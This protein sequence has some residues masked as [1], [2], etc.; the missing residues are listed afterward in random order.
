MS[1]PMASQNQH[2]ADRKT[3]HIVFNSHIDPIWLWPW[4][5]GL[6]AI[7]NTCRSVCNLLDRHPDVDLHQ[8]RGVEIFAD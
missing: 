1:K 6:D 7:L 4:Q 2:P 3:V 8:R 5:S